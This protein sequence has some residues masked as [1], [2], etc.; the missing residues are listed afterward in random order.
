MYVSV[1]LEFRMYNIILFYLA[2]DEFNY[3]T[4]VNELNNFSLF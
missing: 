2:L 4:I 1:V 3:V